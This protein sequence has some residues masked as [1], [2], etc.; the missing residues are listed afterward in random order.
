M[1]VI[2]FNLHDNRKR[3]VLSITKFWHKSLI[4]SALRCAVL[5]RMAPKS[6]QPKGKAVAKASGA[7][8]VAGQPVELPASV[9]NINVHYLAKMQTYLDDVNEHPILQ[10]LVSAAPL[11][12]AE[13]GSQSPY[14][15]AEFRIRLKAANEQLASKDPNN[16]KMQDLNPFYHCGGVFQWANHMLCATAGVQI[17]EADVDK[18]IATDYSN[19]APG[20][21]SH[22][23]TF[24]VTQDDF[25]PMQHKG[26]LMRLSPL[27]FSDAAIKACAQAVMANADDADVRR[28]HK[29][30]RSVRINFV[31]IPEHK[32]AMY[33][34]SA[35]ENLVD[36]GEQVGWTILQRVQMVIR[37][38]HALETSVGKVSSARLALEF[39]AVQIASGNESISAS[40]IDVAMSIESRILVSSS[41]QDILNDLDSRYGSNGPLNSAYKLQTVINRGKVQTLIEWTL[42]SLADDIKMG[43]LEVGE[44]SVKKLNT[45]HC[46][47]AL[48]KHQFHEYFLTTF[49]DKHP[50]STDAKVQIRQVLASQENVRKYLCN[51]PG[52]AN[53]ELSW[54]C[55]YSQAV[56]KFIDLTE[57]IVFGVEHNAS[58]RT[59]VTYHKTIDDILEYQLIKEDIDEVIELVEKEAT[60][61]RTQS[62]TTGVNTAA[63]D[64]S[65]GNAADAAAS[66][67][68]TKSDKIP[69]DKVGECT[70]LLTKLKQLDGDSSA[71]WDGVISR[72][73][74]QYTRVCVPTNR[75]ATR[76]RNQSQ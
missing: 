21:I 41:C 4:S 29:A 19:G 34:F 2:I 32:M 17:N 31:R 1:H 24:A 3:S 38:K 51:Y 57:S 54:R 15:T 71:H 46:D 60:P 12:I 8:G 27:E 72:N 62:S 76:C 16:L 39:A 61:Q 36:Q 40:F 26:S 67:Q 58:L 42:A 6:R 44:C 30:F 23:I 10:G 75:C 66:G 55:S 25:D 7:G 13:G 28:W 5:H 70:N 68:A 33:A 63:S 48:L 73:V 50:F 37:E 9:K 49:L 20:E 47:T 11:A 14:S 65:I 74:R 69:A 56:N 45:V 18:I 53:A 22:P 59:G 35:R 43:F 52:C 64:G